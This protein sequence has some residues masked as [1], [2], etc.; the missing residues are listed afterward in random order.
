M[1][2]IKIRKTWTVTPATKTHRRS[3]PFTVLDQMFSL[4]RY[5]SVVHIYKPS[6]SAAVNAEALRESLSKTLVHFYPMAGRCSPD[7]DR[8]DCNDAGVPFSEAEISSDLE[9][10]GDLAP[11]PELA[12]LL[13]TIDYTQHIS[14]YP[15]LA[16]QVMFAL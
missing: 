14:S 11:T 8:I 3:I 4:P 13:P 2:E 7:G 12:I 10:L 16:V 1:M 6:T 9:A 15:F 5:N